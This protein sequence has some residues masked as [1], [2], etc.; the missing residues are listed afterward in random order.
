[1]SKFLHCKVR[2]LAGKLLG[3][4]VAGICWLPLRS[5]QVVHKSP[6]QLADQYFEA[7]EYYTAGYLYE[8][9]LK[10]A[11]G[12][13]GA[14]AFTTYAKKGAAA[15]GGQNRSRASILYKQAES[16]RLAHYWGKA[17]SAYKK[18]T[19]NSDALYWSAVC[20]RSLENYDAAEED[21]RKYLNAGGTNGQLK[22]A[23]EKEWQ[24]LQY[25]RKQLAAAGAGQVNSSKLK[26]PGSFEKG[27]FAVRA[28]SS[29]K[30]L[31]SSTKTDTARVKGVNPH[32]SRLY[33]ATLKND[34]LDQ[35]TPVVLPVAGISDNQGVA[36]YTADG[37]RV[38][39]TQWKKDKGRIV[40]NIYYIINRGDSGWTKPV[41]L[42]QVNI[43][44]YSSKQPFCS[45]DGVYLYF[46]S[47]RPGGSGAFDIWYA[48]IYE[49]GSAGIPVN[50]GPGINTAG[51]EQAPFYHTSSSTMV[52]ATN[53]RLGMGGYD[54]FSVKGSDKQWGVPRNMGYPINS[55]RDDIYFFAP[56]DT[57]LL[58]TAIVGSDRGT[59]CCLENYLIK[60]SLRNKPFTGLVRD[61]KDNTPVAGADIVLTDPSGKTWATKTD[62][63]GNYSFDTIHNDYSNYR[64]TITKQYYNDTADVVKIND[65][66]DVNLFTDQLVNRDMYIEKKFILNIANVVTVYFD[67]DMSNLKTEAVSKL[68]S[69][70]L[71]LVQL[72]SSTL[73]IS[74]YTDGKGTDEYNKKLSDRRARSCAD[75]FIG[76]GIKASRITFESF[77]ACCPLELELIN[78]RDNPDGRSRNRRALINISKE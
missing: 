75:Y 41:L 1:M 8:Q 28:V 66:A 73:Q 51:D 31:V 54:L 15:A 18:C 11:G 59:G 9:Y 22:E 74:A 40:S 34:S 16:Y 25:I 47:D 38:Y 19:D 52:F 37:N 69:V 49:D 5:Q 67:F 56:E 53:G 32:A 43:D 63:K 7:G 24:T 46:S 78:G 14:P 77:G 35:L 61:S 39:F 62:D 44:G 42:P 23:A 12:N 65:T 13:T 33:Y 58:A 6:L 27:A 70:Y 10:I 50:A 72:P 21:L 3:V 48:P 36:S 29:N 64:I 45:A 30:Y 17:D 76:K 68:D 4:L 20:E 60:R 26:T 55:S 71:V 57:A 2:P